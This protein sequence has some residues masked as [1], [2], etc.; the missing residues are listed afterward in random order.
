MRMLISTAAA[1][2]IAGSAALA[3]QKAP[4]EAMAFAKQVASANAFQIQSSELAQER[5]QSSEVKSFA[6]KMMTEHAKIGEDF[7]AVLQ[8]ANVLLPAPEQPDAELRAEFSKLQ[9]VQGSAF[10]RAYLSA[11]LD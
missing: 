7:K 5:A 11:Q 9:E 3:Q 10:D 2:V 6:A 8:T 1:L 4:A